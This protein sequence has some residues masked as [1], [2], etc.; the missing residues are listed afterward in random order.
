VWVTSKRE[1]GRGGNTREPGGRKLRWLVA[2]GEPLAPLLV[3]TSKHLVVSPPQPSARSS[4]LDAVSTLTS[5]NAA[6]CTC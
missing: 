2:G 3:A 6:L 1:W 5:T 4:V